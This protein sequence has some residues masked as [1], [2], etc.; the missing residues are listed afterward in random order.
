VVE[1]LEFAAGEPLE[2]A[3]VGGGVERGDGRRV[4]PNGEGE[5][6]GN[7]GEDALVAEG[8]GVERHDHAED[9]AVAAELVV[10]EGLAG[11][12]DLSLDGGP[13]GR[14][15]GRDQVLHGGAQKLF[16]GEVLSDGGSIG[17]V[18][19]EQPQVLVAGDGGDPGDHGRTAR[20]QPGG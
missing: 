20:D 7:R 14:G 10:E 13:L 2:R 9:A 3:E 17:L 15:G 11:P 16:E 19:P 6:F 8:I 4:G 12:D 18:A 1:H 5:C